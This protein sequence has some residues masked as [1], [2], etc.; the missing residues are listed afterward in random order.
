MENESYAHA[1]NYTM[2]S[3]AGQGLPKIRLLWWCEA[4]DTVWPAILGEEVRDFVAN[5]RRACLPSASSGRDSAL[6]RGIIPKHAQVANKGLMI[7]SPAITQ[8][9]ASISMALPL[10]GLKR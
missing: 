4:V 6:D 9:C 8:P 10:L 3:H 7:R 1:H 2:Q 5:R